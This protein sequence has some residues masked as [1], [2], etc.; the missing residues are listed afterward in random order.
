MIATSSNLATNLLLDLVGL[1]TACSGVST[2]WPWTHRHPTRCRRRACVRPRHHE[3]R[4][5]RRACPTAAPHRRGARLLAGAVE[6]HD[7]HS[8][9]AGISEGNTARLPRAVRVAHKT[10]T[11]RRSPMMRASSIR[12]VANHTSSPS[13]PN[14][15]PRRRAIEHDCGSVT[16]GLPSARRRRGKQRPSP[17]GRREPHMTAP[18]RFPLSIVDGLR[19]EKP[20][21][22]ALLPG[23]TRYDD[24]GSARHLPRYFYESRR[25]TMRWAFSFHRTSCSGSSFR[26]TC[27]RRCRSERFPGTCRAPSRCSRCVS[28][29]FA[30]RSARSCT[31]R[32]TAATAR[33]LTR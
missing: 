14:G 6:K 20:L 24:T 23:R 5:R 3:S 25:G 7:G 10:A 11:S 4:N 30:P 19:L 31:S 18:T 17:R 1:E 28:S 33:P 8:P 9:R 32:R 26:L 2:S 12:R 13:S 29:A 15:R 27:A 22:D 16:G 21:R